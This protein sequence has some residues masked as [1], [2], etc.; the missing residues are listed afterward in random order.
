MFVHEG[1]S[2]DRNVLPL[3]GTVTRLLVRLMI[4]RFDAGSVPNLFIDSIV[5]NADIQIRSKDS[6][7]IKQAIRSRI[8][9]QT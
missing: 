6:V 1:I 8:L 7:A 2:N 9:G 3:L 5:V 4:T